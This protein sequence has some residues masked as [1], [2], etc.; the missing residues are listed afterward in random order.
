MSARGFHIQHPWQLTFSPSC[1]RSWSIFF[2]TQTCKHTHASLH[3]CMHRHIHSEC[4]WITYSTTLM[5]NIF[6]VV[7]EAGALHV[8]S[9]PKHVHK[10]SFCSGVTHKFDT[11]PE[12]HSTTDPGEKTVFIYIYS[13]LFVHLP[14]KLDS[15]LKQCSWDLRGSRQAKSFCWCAAQTWGLCPVA[16]HPQWSMSPTPHTAHSLCWTGTVKLLWTYLA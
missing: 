2:P 3:A 15:Y 10:Y 7:A 5:V 16:P 4:Q 6:Q 11:Y 8:T 13:G 14:H 12:Q 9:P 1:D